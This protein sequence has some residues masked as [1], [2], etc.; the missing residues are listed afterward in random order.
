MDYKDYRNEENLKLIRMKLKQKRY[1]PEWQ[2]LLEDVFL[3]RVY[4]LD[5]PI[6]DLK[7]DLDNFVSTIDTIRFAPREIFRKENTMGHCDYNNREICLNRGYFISMSMRGI[8]AEKISE[9]MYDTFAHE[10]GH[11]AGKNFFRHGLYKNSNGEYEGVALDEVFVETTANRCSQNR[12]VEDIKRYRAETDG[13]G[14]ITFVSNI[15]AATYG[16]TE[17]E[18]LKVGT[19]GRKEL[20]N[21]LMKDSTD[22]DRA[23]KSFDLIEDN[24]NLLYNAVYK[25]DGVKDENA[26]K[27]ALSGIY[28]NS[29][30]EL[31][32]QL[33]DTKDINDIKL[34][35]ADMVYRR[36]KIEKIMEDIIDENVKYGR[37]SNR[38]AGNIYT[39]AEIC[40]ID[41]AIKMTN[42]DNINRKRQDFAPEDFAH[43]ITLAA[44]GEI[45]KY[46][47]WYKQNYGID[48]S[49]RVDLEDDIT[50]EL[51]Y[52]KYVIREDFDN[53]KQWDNSR[54]INIIYDKFYEESYNLE[55]TEELPVID[56]LE[57]T[58]PLPTV[59]E[60][61]D[62]E[63]LPVIYELN[64]TELT[65]DELAD[66]EEIPVIDELN[67]TEPLPTVGELEDTEELETIKEK[68]IQKARRIVSEFFT[69]IFNRKKLLNPGDQYTNQYIEDDSEQDRY[70]EL[71]IRT[72]MGDMDRKEP[73][74]DDRYKVDETP[75]YNDELNKTK[76]DE[77]ND[78]DR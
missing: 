4:E 71:A 59:D 16:K 52:A 2:D 65:V 14:D 6:R 17:K 23:T 48:I 3:R 10:V 43:A 12:T 62:T 15:L 50:D 27:S 51:E 41:I 37:I 77:E 53:G 68:P 49:K 46:S 25:E 73:S 1:D 64:D 28:E 74:F 9:T 56:D 67:D 61:E 19:R 66:T 45:D 33:E 39:D 18:I 55:D 72:S 40:R 29:I 78:K 70:T 8:S 13:Y 24:L 69:K 26:V 42:I 44:R 57:D 47:E 58:E 30:W 22:K 32:K 7:S 76:D 35:I 36:S 21:L 63:E 31:S 60:L 38:D 54:V 5:Q 20:I 11:A 34:F 75:V